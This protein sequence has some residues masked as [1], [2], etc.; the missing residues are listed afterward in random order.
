[1]WSVGVLVE[2]PASPTEQ[3]SLLLAYNCSRS[4]FITL[5]FLLS[6]SPFSYIEILKDIHTLLYE[7]D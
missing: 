7:I 5:H 4:F 1:M 3:K 2:K 6:F